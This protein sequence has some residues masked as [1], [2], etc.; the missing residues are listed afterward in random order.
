M[1]APGTVGLRRW[2]AQHL[3]ARP[4]P[5]GVWQVR[6]HPGYP[7]F[8]LRGTFRTLSLTSYGSS[9]HA[10][11]FQPEH[12]AAGSLV[13]VPFYDTP[14][15]FGFDSPRT[16]RNGRRSRFPLGTALA[17][18]GLSVLAVPW[19]FEQT[20]VADPRTATATG[21]AG[22]YGPAADLHEQT[23]TMTALGRSIGDL[24]L[25]VRAVREEGFAASGHLGTFGHSLG[26]K[27]ALHLG[28]LDPRVDVVAAHEPGVGFAFSNWDAPWYLGSEVPAGRDQDEIVSLVAPR[29]LL[30]A[31]G[32]DSDGQ[33]NRHLIDVAAGQWPEHHGPELLFH[34]AG[35]PMP[36][37]VVEACSTWLHRRITGNN[38]S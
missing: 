13:V 9:L 33:H 31:G 28:A 3:G 17:A 29:P 36:E 10:E 15:V 27:L 24:M 22:R 6:E 35:H 37:H 1:S 2:W 34:N 32:G 14:P 5:A 8:A 18:R 21:L 26:G 16:R 19:W 12:G 30:I 11:L 25:A 23:H 7:G 38:S 20:A 4:D